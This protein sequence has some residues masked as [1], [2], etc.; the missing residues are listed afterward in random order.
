[1]NPG[2]PQQGV[3]RAAPGGV[4]R[5]LGG[6]EGRQFRRRRGPG[7]GQAL[8]FPADRGIL[9]LHGPEAFPAHKARLIAPPGQ[10]QVRV[11]LAEQEP[12]FAPGGHDAVGL[13]GALGHQVVDE[14]ADVALRPGEDEGVLPPELP[15]GVDPGHEALDR[16]LLI[17]GR[18]VELPRAV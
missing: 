7:A 6:Q 3:Q 17:A 8:D 1:M 9:L 18:A 16:R 14:G 13:V 5:V 10:P 2:P 12:V 4:R 11:V 15:H